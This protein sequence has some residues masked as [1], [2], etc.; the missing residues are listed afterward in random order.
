MDCILSTFALAQGYK[1]ELHDSVDSTNRI[2]LDE[3]TENDRDKLWIV[4]AQQTQGRARRGRVWNSPRGNLYASLLLTKGIIPET[5]AT[6]GFVAGVSLAEA[7]NSILK[8]SGLDLDIVRLKWPNDVLLK[9][10]KASGILLELKKRQDCS[11]ALVIGIGLNVEHRFEDAPYPTQSLKNLGI[12]TDY[13]KV[14]ERLSHFWTLNHIAFE[15]SDGRKFIRK[16][17]LEY[18]AYLG[19]KITVTCGGEI[20]EGVF[21]GIDEEFNCLVTDKYH[22]QKK[23]TAGDVHFGA[24]ASI[25]AGRY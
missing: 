4:A 24:V 9:G 12:N 17:W 19:E 21:N 14:F 25:N 1:L 6:F 7:I 15:S 18:A 10:A 2:A 20:I 5:A 16:K 13:K 23:I 11:Y 22:H 8:E 3:N